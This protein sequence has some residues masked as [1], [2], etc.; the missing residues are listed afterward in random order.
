M[1]TQS[2][3]SNDEPALKELLKKDKLTSR[4]HMLA[5]RIV[6]GMITELSRNDVKIQTQT[7][8]IGERNDRLYAEIFDRHDDGG[9][10]VRGLSSSFKRVTEVQA[11]H[12]AKLAD[13][14]KSNQTLRRIIP[15]IFEFF[16]ENERLPTMDETAAEYAKIMDELQA[17]GDAAAAGQEIFQRVAKSMFRCS[18]CVHWKA[19]SALSLPAGT[20]PLEERCEK[21]KVAVTCPACNTAYPLPVDPNNLTAK[22]GKCQTPLVREV[23]DGENAATLCRVYTVNKDQLR[24]RCIEEGVLPAIAEALLPQE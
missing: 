3:Y 2:V 17:M 7:R 19:G 13:V 15:W 20:E 18:G 6:V 1:S 11:M 4:Q 9:Q 14:F 5:L 10:V 16:G 22:C 21:D 8:E 23:E 12:E 24:T